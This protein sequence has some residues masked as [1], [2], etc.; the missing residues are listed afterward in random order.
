[1]DRE[2]ESSF[3]R[4]KTLMSIFFFRF[5]YSLGYLLF[6]LGSIRTISIE[7]ERK[8]RLENSESLPRGRHYAFLVVA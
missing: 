5:E 4:F 7:N 6:I 3:R 8:T 1:M 2:L